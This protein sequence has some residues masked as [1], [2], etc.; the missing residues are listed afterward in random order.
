MVADA[1]ADAF[2]ELLIGASTTG[3]GEA[4]VTDEE[5]ALVDVDDARVED[6]LAALLDDATDAGEFTKMSF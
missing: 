4:I 1:L 2:V 5:E 6:E 3:D